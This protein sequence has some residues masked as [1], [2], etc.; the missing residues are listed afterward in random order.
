MQKH[1]YLEKTDSTNLALG[2]MLDESPEL[3]EWT[4]LVAGYQQAGRGQAGTSWI[5]DKDQNLLCSILLRPVFLPPSNQFTLNKAIAIGICETLQ[6]FFRE[7]DFSIKW[8]NDIY[9]RYE[10]IAGTLIENRI[11][12]NTFEI[13]V[14]GIGINL[15]QL[16]FPEEIPN[17]TSLKKI[18]GLHYNPA[19]CIPVLTEKIRTLYEM[20]RRG[21]N[22]EI[23]ALYLDKLLGFNEVMKF[24]VSGKALVG[25]I[26]GV[27]EHG[28]LI[29]SD[30][31]GRI[32]SFGMKEITFMF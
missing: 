6:F 27:D 15:N 26:T 8:P 9:A 19:A 10:K 32:A 20:I 23:D 25:K 24:E 31:Q 3:E 30:R 28:K 14:A 7:G 29:L 2:R 18:S 21:Q 4:T 12:G 16:T 1:I 5:S 11:L 22:R 13:C 17:P